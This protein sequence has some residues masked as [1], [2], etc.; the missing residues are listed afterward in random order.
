MLEYR[1]EPELSLEEVN[2]IANEGWKIVQYKN[3]GTEFK[4]ILFVRGTDPVLI[5]TEQAILDL[6]QE[7]ITNP[8]GEFYVKKEISYGDV[9]LITFLTLFLVLSITGFLLKFF[10]PKLVNFK[11]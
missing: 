2:T 10:L 7:K 4:E 5:Q 11:R 8:S 6:T 1:V 3:F 9:I